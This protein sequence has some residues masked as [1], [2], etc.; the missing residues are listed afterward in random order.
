MKEVIAHITPEQFT[1]IMTAIITAIGVQIVNIIIALRA[2]KK[3]EETVKKVEAHDA[4]SAAR[5]REAGHDPNP[6][7]LPEDKGNV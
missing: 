5:A 4:R 7:V 2:G 6:R 1:A 3:V